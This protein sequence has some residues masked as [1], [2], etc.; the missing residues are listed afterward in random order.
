MKSSNQGAAMVKVVVLSF[1]VLVLF[2]TAGTAARADAVDLNTWTAESYAS[3]SG[4]DPG[5]WTV[6]SDGTE[7]TQ[8]VNGK[9]TLL[10]SDFLAQGTATTGKIKV[11]GSDDDFIGFVLGFDPGDSSLSSAD[12]LLLDWK[13]GDEGLQLQWR[14]CRQ[15]NRG[16]RGCWPGGVPCGGRPDGG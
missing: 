16:I 3:V 5:V 10:Y 9:P 12:Y 15:H 8:S 11:T 1:C 2:A 4:F 13:R 14:S 7:V 6:S